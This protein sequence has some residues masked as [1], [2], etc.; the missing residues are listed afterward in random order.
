VIT[1][2]G[3]L[4]E[5][6]GQMLRTALTLSA[7]TAQAFEM[8]RIRA[9]RP[10]AGLGLN[11]LAAIRAASLVCGARVHGLFDG[12]PDL[13]FEPGPVAAGNFGFDMGG[14]GAVSLVLQTVVPVLAT[15]PRASRI[16]ITGGT[17]VPLAP[18]FEYLARPWAA[19]VAR[20]G[21]RASFTLDQAGFHPRGGGVV[22]ASVEGGWT[23]PATLDLTERGPLVEVRGVAG[24]GKVKGDLARRMSEAAKSRL[25]EARRLES[26]WDVVEPRAAAPGSFFLLEAVFE[27]GGAG[28]AYLG[29][30]GLRPELLGERAARRLLRFLDGESATDPFLADQ[31]AV[32]LALAG[33]GGR[34]TTSAVSAHLETVVA[35]ASAFGVEARTWGRRGGPGGLEVGRC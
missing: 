8:R 19:A 7:A 2:D 31:L 25:W 17:H 32:P 1:L 20:L 23:R 18:T 14:A 26:T 10:R 24:A 16:T 12:S 29:E 15:V 33:G 4:G 3:G 9:R 22:S 35:V 30:R 27:K 13:R 28:F 11:D 21:L 6:A 5:G 34:V